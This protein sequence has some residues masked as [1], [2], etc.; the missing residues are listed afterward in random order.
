MGLEID[1]IKMNVKV[2]SLTEPL[3]HFRKK[4]I[5]TVIIHR[6]AGDIR[7]R[8]MQLPSKVNTSSDGE[9]FQG[10]GLPKGKLQQK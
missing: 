9:S 5:T 3:S 6:V 10:V 1:N 2:P 7:K 8:C 4:N